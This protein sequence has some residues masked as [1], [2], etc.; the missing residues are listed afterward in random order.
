MDEFQIQILQKK[1][2]KKKNLNHFL[3][4]TPTILTQ[5]SK[6]NLNLN[7]ALPIFDGESIYVCPLYTHLYYDCMGH[8]YSAVPIFDSLLWSYLRMHLVMESSSTHCLYGSPTSP[9]LR[10]TLYLPTFTMW[11]Y[12]TQ[13][14]FLYLI[15]FRPPLNAGVTSTLN[16]QF[17]KSNQLINFTF[18]WRN[19]LY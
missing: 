4:I 8:I 1:F 5:L 6:A 3:P 13:L 16:K 11:Q 14:G 10:L 19:H 12:S 15:S 17:D 7:W 18:D 9:L 2:Q